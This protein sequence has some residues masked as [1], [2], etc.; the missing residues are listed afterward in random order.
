MPADQAVQAPDA[1]S[2]PMRDIGGGFKAPA[3]KEWRRQPLFS[4]ISIANGAKSAQFFAPG[5]GDGSGRT[6][7]DTNVKGQGKLANSSVF[8]VFSLSIKIMTAVKADFLQLA[9]GIA[10]LKIGDSR[11]LILP[12]FTAGG[13]GGIAAGGG[14]ETTAQYLQLG[15]SVQDVYSLVSPVDSR[16]AIEG[17]KPFDVE[18]QWASARSLSASTV[19]WAILD[20]LLAGAI[21]SF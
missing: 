1:K 8:T 10:F 14:A 9:D 13:M 5:Q 11:P 2:I 19:A 16:H 4:R 21:D 12:I 17:G 6:L 15:F 3:G 7:N 18:L 20:G